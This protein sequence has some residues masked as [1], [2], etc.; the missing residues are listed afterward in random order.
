MVGLYFREK[1]GKKKARFH[2]ILEWKDKDMK[3]KGVG[4]EDRNTNTGWFW[5]VHHDVL[6]EWCYDYEERK[7]YIEEEK[8]EDERELRLRLF[9]RVEGEIPKELDEARKKYDEAEEKYNEVWKYYEAG[10]K[11]NEAEE[12]CEEVKK[13]YEELGRKYDEVRKYDEEIKE[14][15]KK[16]CPGCPWNGW[17]IF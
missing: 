9:K 10:E 4:K 8:P 16:E 12:K 11:Y 14:L 7:K 2:L 6:L 3:G 15:H 1:I 5:H 13:N 17:T